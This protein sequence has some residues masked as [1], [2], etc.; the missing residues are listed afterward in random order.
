MHLFSQKFYDTNEF[1]MSIT[2]LLLMQPP[3]TYILFYFETATKTVVIQ[4]SLHLLIYIQNIVAFV[5]SSNVLVFV[6]L[7]SIS[8]NDVQMKDIITYNLHYLK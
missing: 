1:H 5:K 7:F 3:C 4:Y 6:K 8:F 2:L